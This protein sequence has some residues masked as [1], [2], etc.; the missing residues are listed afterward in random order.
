MSPVSATA[1]ICP[2]MKGNVALFVSWRARWRVR[3]PRFPA[4]GV[5]AEDI[6]ADLLA[7]TAAAS[8]SA[9]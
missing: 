7:P 2:L 5:S 9:A 8:A 4:A 3:F 1:M 6:A